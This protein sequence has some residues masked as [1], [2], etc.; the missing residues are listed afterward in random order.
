ML[1]WLQLESETEGKV[2]MYNSIKHFGKLFKIKI[3]P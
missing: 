1:T 3:G 2:V